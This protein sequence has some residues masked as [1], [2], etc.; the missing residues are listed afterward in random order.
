MGFLREDFP[1]HVGNPDLDWSK[2]LSAQP[3]AVLGHS[4]PYGHAPML[5][6]TRLRGSCLGHSAQ[7][8]TD[9]SSTPLPC[10]S[11]VPTP[12]AE[13]GGADGVLAEDGG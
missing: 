6:V 9:G 4:V 13:S 5:H 8:S 10:L 7:Y 3:L 2:A 12:V 11:Q 1:A